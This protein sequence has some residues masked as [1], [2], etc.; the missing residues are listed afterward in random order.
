MDNQAA[1]ALYYLQVNGKISIVGA[2]PGDPELLTLKALRAIQN[3]DV[4]LYD[5][6]V[7]D[8]ILALIPAGAEAIYAGKFQGEQEEM[9]DFIFRMLEEFGRRGKRVVRLKG[10]DPLVFGRGAEEWL[11]LGELGLEL[12]VIPGISSAIAVPGLAGVPPT[13]RGVADGFAV[14][15]GHLRKD[16]QEV[17]WSKYARIDTLIILM[18]VATRQAIARELIRFGRDARQPVAFVEKGTSDAERVVVAELRDVAEGRVEVRNP[19]VFVVGEVVRLRER[20]AGV[21]AA[22]ENSGSLG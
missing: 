8:E 4:V 20:L 12:E 15:T 17:D 5:R 2:G 9:Q 6:L 18:G 10:G 21:M 13:Y 19:A 3:A 7:S 11:R 22:A 16:G 14:V 1:S